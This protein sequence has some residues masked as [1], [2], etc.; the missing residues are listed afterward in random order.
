MVMGSHLESSYGRQGAVQ[1]FAELDIAVGYAEAA[2][3]ATRTFVDFQAFLVQV[4]EKSV[5]MGKSIVNIVLGNGTTHRPLF[6]E[7]W[8]RDAYPDGNDAPRHL[9]SS[10]SPSSTNNCGVYK[11]KF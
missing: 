11:A 2:I 5:P 8:L 7:K 9:E 1:L 4:V 6:L 3:K 10:S